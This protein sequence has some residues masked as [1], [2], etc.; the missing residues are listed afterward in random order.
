[1]KASAAFAD[2]DVLADADF[3]ALGRADTAIPGTLAYCD[4]VF[5]LTQALDNPNVVCVLTTAA[6][7]QEARGG[8]GVV[9]SA[10]PRT[11]FYRF[12]NRLA[13]E[14]RRVQRVA[15]HIGTGC[16][17]DESAIVSPGARIGERVTLGAR[18]VVS[19]DVEIGDDAFVDAAVVLGAEGLLYFVDD[20]GNKIAVRHTGGVR[21]GRGVT[22]LSQVVV[23]RAIH[24]PAE[25]RIGD[26]SIV[27]IATNVGHEAELGRNCVVSSNCVVARGVRVDDNAYVGSS[28]VLREYVRVGRGAQVKAGSVVVKDVD[29]GQSVSGNFAV[30]HTKHLREHAR[31][32]R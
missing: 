2:A 25:T 22:L 28:C 10:S 11:A 1:M 12:H 8:K 7:A 9:V 13:A 17:I 32:S 26:Y 24:R 23:A 6:L 18:V 15:P 19:D 3:D 21:I 5:H 29:A 4:T 31:M 30:D 20:A 16:R 27:G 14:R